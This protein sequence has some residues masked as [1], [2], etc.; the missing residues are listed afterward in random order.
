MTCVFGIMA[1]VLGNLAGNA[2]AFGIYIMIAAGRDPVNSSAD[3]YQ[4]GPVIGLAIVVLTVCA[5]LHV[6][7]RRGGI[8]INNAFAVMKIG[9]LIAIAI[10]G[11]VHASGKL[12]SKGINDPLSHA[13]LNITS[14]MINNAKDSNFDPFTSFHTTHHDVGSVVSSFIFAIYPF[15][16]FEQPFYVLS[17]V[18]RPKTT[19]PRATITAILTALVLYM[20]VNVSY[21]CVVPQESYLNGSNTID[22][23]DA[24]LHDLFDSTYGPHTAQRV[25]AALIAFSIFGNI[26]VLTFTAARVK[27][28]IAKEGILPKSL[29]F[30]TGHATPWARF[31]ARGADRSGT[32]DINNHLEQTPMAALGLHWFTSIFLVLVTA[33]LQP[34]TAYSFLVTL[35]SYVNV[36][37]LGC[38]TAGGLL[39]L[40][41]DSWYYG[42]SGR[43]WAAKASWK[44]PL[45]PLHA[46]IYFCSM[47]FLLFASFVKPAD[48]S[49]FSKA[50]TGYWWFL[51]PAIGLSSLGWG[52][53]WW[54]GLEMAM[55]KGRWRLVVKRTPYLERDEDGNYVQKLELVE[56]ETSVR[57]GGHRHVAAPRNV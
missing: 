49:P 37:I 28:E 47:A 27:Q 11:F 23:A 53:A 26:L 34:A 2:V 8:W 43:N 44:P 41:L 14:A 48:N 15:S 45:D 4:K 52:V 56:H 32:I 13:P 17:E 36:A 31:R 18:A 30:A 9:I 7:S 5:F 22:M 21:F 46:I 12:K 51:V 6:F 19:F 1:I 25:M 29:F 10:L 55:W 16:G 40:K 33:V 20:L 39:Y 50:A 54:S 57:V 24:F 42:K 3:N 35:Y 38:L